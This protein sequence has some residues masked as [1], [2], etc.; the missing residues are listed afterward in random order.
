M[1]GW[2]W[3]SGRLD[4]V[5][6]R[7]SSRAGGVPFLWSG[8]GGEVASARSKP[9][10]HEPLPDT[11]RVFAGLRMSRATFRYSALRLRLRPPGLSNVLFEHVS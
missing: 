10:R 2:R 6:E 5:A 8:G 9:Q 11:L 3:V 4:G 1:A 7:N